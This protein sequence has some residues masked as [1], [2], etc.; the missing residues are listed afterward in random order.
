MG[1]KDLLL[2]LIL[3]FV[4]DRQRQEENKATKEKKDLTKND[5][6]K[7]FGRLVSDEAKKSN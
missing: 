6:L 5:V 7:I 4:H 2:D 3:E 1:L